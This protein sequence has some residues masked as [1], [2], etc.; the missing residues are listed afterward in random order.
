ME[1]ELKDLVSDPDNAQSMIEALEDHAAKAVEQDIRAHKKVWSNK[2]ETDQE[3]ATE[4]AKTWATRHAGHRVTC[5]SC[6]SS[7]LLQGNPSGVVSTDVNEGEVIQRQTMLPTSFECIACGL[8]ISGLSKL[9]ACGL[10][11]AFTSRSVYTPAEYFDLYTEDDLE[12]ARADAA[13]VYEEDFN[14]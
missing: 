12:Q 1:K 8:R 2:S 13:P 9:S 5:P 14:E 3:I 7:A 11:D 10:G 6:S 4:Q